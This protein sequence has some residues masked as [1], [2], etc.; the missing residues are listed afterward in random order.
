MVGSRNSPVSLREP[1]LGE[2]AFKRRILRR[3]VECE[4]TAAS[5]LHSFPLRQFCLVEAFAAEAD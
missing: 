5:G 2:G 1:A 3:L 4:D